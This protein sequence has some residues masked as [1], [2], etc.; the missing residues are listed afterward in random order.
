MFAIVKYQEKKINGTNLHFSNNYDGLLK[1]VF[2]KTASV[3]NGKVLLLQFFRSASS[4][5]NYILHVY[6]KEPGIQV[7][8]R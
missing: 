5:S 7:T 1:C 3:T 8:S 6:S 4:D 2:P